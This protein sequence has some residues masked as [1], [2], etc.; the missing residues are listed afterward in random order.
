MSQI[1]ETKEKHPIKDE[2]AD[3][4]ILAVTGVPWFADYPNYLVDGLI[5]DDFDSNKKNFF[6]HDYRFYVWDDL[7]LYK[8]GI[9]GLVQRCVLEEEQRDILRACHNSEYGGHFSGDR[10]IKKVIHSGLYWPTLFKYAQGIVKECDRCQ[11]TG[12]ISKRNQMPQNGML[13]VEL[14]NV[15][16]I[17]FMGPFSPSFRKNY[18]LVVVDYV[19]KW[20]EVVALPM[21]DVKVVVCFLKNYIFA[22][23]G[24][25]LALISDEGTHFMN[26]LMENMLRKY[27]VKHKI[28]TTY[29]PQTSGQ[30]EVSNRQIKR[31]LEKVVSASRKD[32]SIKLEDAL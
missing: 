30:V 20:V 25:P 18:I 15:W 2:F 12:N 9:D 29:H 22:R 6:L 24:V 3:E 11:R 8:K 5:P 28:S 19:S 14:F 4:H 1:K 7:L 26:K 23:F 13:E 32:L 10:K 21:N 17:D 16:G 31:I 27:N